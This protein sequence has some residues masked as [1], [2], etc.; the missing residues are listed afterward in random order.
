MDIGQMQLEP[1]RIKMQIVHHLH[2]HM[3]GDSFSMVN[4]SVD[5]VSSNVYVQ[6]VLSF[7]R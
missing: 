7:P 6:M 3:P 2:G 4:C 1:Q 5:N